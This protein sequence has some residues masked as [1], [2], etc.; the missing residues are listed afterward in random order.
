MLPDVS[1]FTPEGSTLHQNRLR[2]HWF[3]NSPN[4]GRV[5]KRGFV[6]KSAK[7][8]A[9]SSCYYLGQNKLKREKR[10]K[11]KGR[12]ALPRLI[13]QLCCGLPDDLPLSSPQAENYK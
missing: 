2:L 9:Q 1:V 4:D 11:V 12:P 8:K 5:N 3:Q 7:L 13:R 6:T 10:P